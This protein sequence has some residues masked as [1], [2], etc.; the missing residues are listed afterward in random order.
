[1]DKKIRIVT[2][3]GTFHADE[4]LAVAA[5]ELYFNGS[6]VYEVVRSRDPLVWKT[7]D[8]LIDVGGEY[9]PTANKFDHH[10]KG[11][12]GKRENGV[13][14][15]AFGL[16]WKHFGEKICGDVSVAD[17]VDRRLV[18]PIDLA[19]NGIDVYRPTNGIHPYLLHHIVVAFR[20]TWKEGENYD[21][22]FAELVA[23]MKRILE[24]EIAVERDNQEGKRIVEQIYRETKEKRIILIDGQYPWYEVLAKYP[25]PL[26]VV[27][28]KH[29]STHWEVECVR[30]DI[31]SFVNR[32]DLPEAWA[33][34]TD[35]AL[36]RQTGVPD[37][38]F[39]HNGRYVA[40]ARTKEG[41]LRLAELALAT[42]RGASVVHAI[43]VSG[44]I[45]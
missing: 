2:H 23:F 37:A 9:D 11:G 32:K 20:P 21:T 12:S 28:P 4:L 5:L 42:E 1:M 14:Y 24:R 35:G 19:D 43:N 6:I 44:V 45:A 10:Q 36:A 25:E 8:F 29:Q 16:I 41:A 40:V 13:P 3:S 22:R 7:A 39:C 38:V 17:A 26:F 33:G 15:S 31:S 34:Q 30:D 18:Q 27:K